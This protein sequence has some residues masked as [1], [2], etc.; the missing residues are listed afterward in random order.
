MSRSAAL[1]DSL[2]IP[3]PEGEGMILDGCRRVL[4]P[5][6]FSRLPGAVGDMLV[7]SRDAEHLLQDWIGH[8]R[9]LASA[10]GWSDVDL[11]TRTFSGGA[12][13]Y[14]AAPVD[15][16]FTATFVIEAAWH[17]LASPILGMETRPLDGLI[18]D[19][20]RI[21]RSE[22]TPRLAR[23]VVGAR[24]RGIDVLLEDDSVTIGH[25]EGSMSW[26]HEEVPDTPDWTALHNIPLALVT[27]TNGKTTTTRLIAA[28]AEAAGKI[29]GLSSTECVKV[30]DRILDTGDY[31]GPSGARLL[32]REKSLEVGILEVARG[33][34]LR[35]GLLV[36]Q[37]A[38]AVVTNVAADH[39]G[40]Y[41]INTVEDLA[42]VKLSV[43][44]ALR[45]GGTL[46]LNADDALLAG[47]TAISDERIA[48]FSLDPKSP[49]VLA[50]RAKG[51]SCGWIEDGAIVLSDGNSEVGLVDVADVPLTLAGAARY[52]IENALGAALVAR[53]LGIPDRAICAAL[54]SFRSD[55]K[56][57]PGRANEFVVRGARVFVD[58]AHNPHSIAAITAALAAVPAK[59]RFVLLTHAGDRSDEDIK[60]LVRGAFA[61]GPDFVAAAENPKY[62]RGRQSGEVSGLIRAQAIKLGMKSDQIFMAQSPSHG[63]AMILDVLG[64]GDLA[65]LLVH[66]ERDQIFKLLEQA[67]MDSQ[68]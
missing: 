27:G 5:N 6:L 59:R 54:T 63:A 68:I 13:L 18:A 34:I 33:G 23:L 14:L 32:L 51:Q 12:S 44:R 50:A 4:G 10:L 45:P 19:L 35:R 21:S 36:S 65:L 43:R 30:G 64:A 53:A 58:F 31:S 60:D 9:T 15:Q 67:G 41:G 56:D 61:L 7:G 20:G 16:L 40:Q 55:P 66:D 24:Q 3:L 11:R 57:N 42:Q 2:A 48:W 17:L 22:A 29:A 25:G 37:A 39:L 49:L 46:V 1:L 26:A 8:V 38:A 62:L 47:T 28:M 52:N